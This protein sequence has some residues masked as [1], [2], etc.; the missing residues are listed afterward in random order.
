[1]GFPAVVSADCSSLTLAVCYRIP[2]SF[3]FTK[4]QVSVP[5][6]DLYQ[7]LQLPVDPEPRRS[8]TEERQ[9]VRADRAPL[10]SILLAI[11]T[12]M[13]IAALKRGQRCT[14]GRGNSPT[15]IK[16]TLKAAPQRAYFT[17]SSSTGL[18]ITSSHSPVTQGGEK[19]CLLSY[20][21]EEPRV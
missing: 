17:P 15:T 2:G 12:A 7:L 16:L 19:G 6:L 11:L 13:I 10:R 9:T 1:M 8:P 20:N 5:A 14:E 18:C 21:R 3:A 4:A